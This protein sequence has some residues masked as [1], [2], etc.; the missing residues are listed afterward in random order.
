MKKWLLLIIVML[1]SACASYKADTST[2][3]NAIINSNLPK[4]LVKQFNKRINNNGYLEFE[5]I[6]YSTFSKDIMYKVDWL[7]SNGFVLR[8]VLNEEYQYLRIP[9]KQEVIIHKISADLRAKDF[10]I[11]IKTKN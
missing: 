10:R 6:L 8:D 5:V 1:F 7:D 3:N 9:A 4:S 2:S 11:N